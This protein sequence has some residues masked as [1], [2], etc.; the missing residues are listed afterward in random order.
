MWGQLRP[1]RHDKLDMLTVPELDGARVAA[2]TRFVLTPRENPVICHGVFS[3]A[4]E[5]VWNKGIELAEK[6]PKNDT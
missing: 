3:S 4:A 1:R 5:C 6:V 2:N